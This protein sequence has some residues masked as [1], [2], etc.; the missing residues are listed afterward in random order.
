MGCSPWAHNESDTAERLS[1]LAV[2]LLEA[3]PLSSSL[4]SLC[5]VCFFRLILTL[6]FDSLVNRGGL[7]FP[8]RESAS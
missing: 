1:T 2:G 7:Q 6:S 3:S 8:G 5:S 4:S